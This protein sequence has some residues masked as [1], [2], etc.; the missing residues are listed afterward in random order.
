MTDDDLRLL[1]E[2]RHERISEADF[3]T[4]Q[5]RLRE[6]AEMRAGLR[7]LAD[8]EAG[9]TA[10]AVKPLSISIPMTPE[11][12][13]RPAAAGSPVWLPW[14]I[15]TAA[16]F[17]AL[18]GWLPRSAMFSPRNG[19]SDGP[20]R[21]AS[22]D[23]L[24]WGQSAHGGEDWTT[25]STYDL[26]APRSSSGPVP[27]MVRN[28]QSPMRVDHYSTF[29]KRPV[30][31]P[32]PSLPGLE[33]A[34]PPLEKSDK[35][36]LTDQNA[37][38]SDKVVNRAK[39]E[40]VV[41]SLSQDVERGEAVISGE[42]AFEAEGQLF[43]AG[44]I[45][46]AG[47]EGSGGTV[48]L[49]DE[50][51][52]T[53]SESVRGL[54]S[55]VVEERWRSRA[56]ERS[57]ADRRSSVQIGH[58]GYN[59]I[60]G[61]VGEI[62]VEAHNGNV[63]RNPADTNAN[64]VLLWADS[65]TRFNGELSSEKDLK[66]LAKVS[67]KE[68]LFALEADAPESPMAEP[69]AAEPVDRFYHRDFDPNEFSNGRAG[70]GGTIA[71]SEEVRE[72]S[73]NPADD[74]ARHW[75]M[76]G[77]GG[78]DIHYDESNVLSSK[79][80]SDVGVD[81]KAIDGVLAEDQF[82]FLFKDSRVMAG[83]NVPVDNSTTSFLAQ[84]TLGIYGDISVN[85]GGDITDLGSRI[86]NSL[87]FDF[88]INGDEALPLFPLETSRVKH[89]PVRFSELLAANEAFST[90]SL[91]VSDVSFKLAQASLANHQW[92]EAEKIRIEE[93]VNAPDYG[94]PM[95]STEERIACRHE[96]AIHP[97]YASR[98]LLRI[99][100]RTAE[101]GRSSQTPLR[102]TLL[103]DLS[104]SMDR[105]D[106]RQSIQRAFALLAQQL[107]P[108][109]Q[110]TLIG[111]ARQP[112]LLADRVS[113]AEAEELLTRIIGNT[114]SEG[115]TNL[116]AALKAAFDKALEQKLDGAQNRIV[117][118]TDGAANLG[119]AE[120]ERLRGIVEKM[121]HNGIAF[122]AAGVGADGLNDEVL[123]ALTRNG[124]GRYY[125]LNRPEDADD[126]FAKQIAGALRPAAMNV[127]VQ[128]EF[129]PAR[130]GRYKLFGYEKHRLA[131]EDFRNDSVD[132]A[133]LAAAEA[134]V[135]IYQFEPLP[136]GVGDVGTVS[137]RFRDMSTGQMVEK[138]WPI[139]Y[140][141]SAPRISEAA[142]SIRI[143]TSAALLAAKLKNDPVGDSADWVELA[144]II[145][146]LPQRSRLDPRVQNLLQMIEQ[147]RALSG[148]E[149]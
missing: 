81:A 89:A 149:N 127:K 117:L 4:M 60:G 31:R 95:P 85:A 111:F 100:M 140:E 16:C 35:L 58:G 6:D 90:F 92:P 64:G 50:V 79:R 122:D 103:L 44:N 48:D 46:A 20:V 144:R 137:V 3:A 126:G 32:A 12:A 88:D 11:P 114:V 84:D 69:A 8:I 104:G 115:G 97:F 34:S 141:A 76:I 54:K 59:G 55:G 136:S 27:D 43:I 109:D 7:A 93:F 91:N 80:A 9:L 98:N 10:L 71:N 25:G 47:G 148:S 52:A 78:H 101:A 124:D 147:A 23:E 146:E 110:V 123:E 13:A 26:Q 135:A 41:T 24:S 15:A 125:F 40:P 142:P 138:R 82:G 77:H 67:E 1:D 105:A 51:L 65:G 72:K 99:S 87:Y 21:I 86:E 73:E 68:P 14:A 129:N 107:L 66:R 29:A 53:T 74:N 19:S 143:A 42:V 94:D 106:R 22:I 45:S 49:S 118:L 121:R 112:R 102:L 133:E 39:S 75:G 128:V 108:N 36:L 113:G 30:A 132:A 139:P 131:T 130:V 2:W 37:P 33:L 83:R 134:G 18:A 62:Q 61:A 56:V 5:T 63:E 120:P 145:R 119:D 70:T 116:D 96:Q 38:D 17:V 57:D 28:G